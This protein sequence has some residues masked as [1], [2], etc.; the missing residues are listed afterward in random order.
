MIR[1]IL[2]DDEILSRVGIQ[3]MIDGQEDIRVDGVFSGAQEALEWLRGNPADIV[4]TDIEMAEM[5]GLEFIRRI[6]E[7]ELAA[8]III[9]SCHDD[10]GYAQQ[11]ISNGTDSYMLKFSVTQKTLTDEIHKV[12]EKTKKAAPER[13]SYVRSLDEGQDLP[14][15]GTY[16]VGILRPQA[17]DK[18]MFDSMM[19]TRL[20]DEIIT[21]AKIGTYFAPYNR[22]N[23]VI[24]RFERGAEGEELRQ[25]L[26]EDIGLIERSVSEYVGVRFLWG[27]SEP[28]GQQQEIHAHYDQAKEAL[29]QVFY[30]PNQTVFHYERRSVPDLAISFPPD[31]YLDPGGEERFCS[32]LTMVL[33]KARFDRIPVDVLTDRLVQAL[34]V[35]CFQVMSAEGFRQDEIRSWSAGTGLLA[36]TA[37]AKDVLALENVV[38]E[39][40]HDF[41]QRLIDEISSDEL[42][43]VF[44]YI[45]QNLREPIAL[46]DL[47]ELAGLSVSSFSKKF[48]DRTGMTLV[49]Y[50]NEQRIERAKVLIRADNLSLSEIAEEC[51]FSSVNYLVRVFRKVT[52]QTISEFK[53]G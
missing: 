42:G 35:M 4:I 31:G 2:V 14:E 16:V 9:L 22:E 51:G 27:L 29:E 30:L 17:T 10:F 52:G 11:A 18:V 38:K 13:R 25:G 5:D 34:N 19:L 3:S 45:Q 1:V 20:L 24:F 32:E 23:F 41:R 48:K 12:Y 44:A 50:L 39:A 40:M 26:R 33:K 21:R 7:Q 8:G 47:A 43:G 46:N 28:F 15:D 37:G 36:R 53:A 6:R 49:Q